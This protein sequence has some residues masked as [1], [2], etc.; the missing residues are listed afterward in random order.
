MG[1]VICFRKSQPDEKEMKGSQMKNLLKAERRIG[2]FA[3]DEL[4][5]AK[6]ARERE[7]RSCESRGKGTLRYPTQ[8]H[9][10]THTQE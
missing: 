2:K 4:K 6:R 3:C 8:R 7:R 10:R 5:K 9:T 1:Q